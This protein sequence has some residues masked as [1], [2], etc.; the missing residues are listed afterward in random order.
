MLFIACGVAVAAQGG[1]GTPKTSPQEEQFERRIFA[2]ESAKQDLSAW[3]SIFI[4]GITL[5]AVAN[6][7]LSVWQVG[8]IARSEVGKAVVDYDQKFS[9]FLLRE[10]KNLAER[11][12]RFESAISELSKQREALSELLATYSTD[13][14]RAASEADRISA[15]AIARLHREGERILEELR[16][17]FPSRS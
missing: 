6:V 16:V 17:E 3:A 7:G 4:G 5:L 11:L 2:L 12:S 9:G 15:G 14:S 13:A 10:E 1:T 8:S